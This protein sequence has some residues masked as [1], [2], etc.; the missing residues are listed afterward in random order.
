M[1][2]RDQDRNPAYNRG[3]KAARLTCH[4]ALTCANTS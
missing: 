3:W 2:W 4:N 1:P